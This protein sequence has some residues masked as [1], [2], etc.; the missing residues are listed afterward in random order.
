MADI[1][2]QN[3]VVHIVV[4]AG[5]VLENSEDNTWVGNRVVV[6][7]VGAADEVEDSKSLVSE[8]LKM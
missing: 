5:V 8:E 7:A 3:I 6:V 4:V 1:D 2:Q